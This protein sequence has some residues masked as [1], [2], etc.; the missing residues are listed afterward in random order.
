MSGLVDADGHI[1]DTE[2]HYRKYMEP[3]YDKRGPVGVGLDAFDR[4][5][6]GTLGGPNTID[7]QNWLDMLDKSGMETTVLYPTT[8][9]G[10]GFIND[11]DYATAFCRAYNNYV[12]EEFCK[13][14]P[15]L[16][17]RG[18]AAIAGPGG[19]GQGDATGSTGSGSGWRHAGGRWPLSVGQASV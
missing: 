1:R 3:P 17:G 13:V 16:A 11:P 2:Q 14:S 7:A 4:A 6:F 9:L 8:G 15:R 12:S 18:P 19:G 5:M 10:V